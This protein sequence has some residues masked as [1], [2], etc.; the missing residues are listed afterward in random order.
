VNALY[1]RPKSLPPVFPW[2][3]VPDDHGYFAREMGFTLVRT[4]YDT[5]LDPRDYRTW[6]SSAAPAAM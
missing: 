5:S 1:E 2:P 4:N 3:V 6:Q